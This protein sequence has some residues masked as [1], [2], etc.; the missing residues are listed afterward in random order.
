MN[1]EGKHFRGR[2]LSKA[3]KAAINLVHRYPRALPPP[4]LL[5]A[6]HDRLLALLQR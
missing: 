6:R 2:P 1:V 5:R 3:M 4:E